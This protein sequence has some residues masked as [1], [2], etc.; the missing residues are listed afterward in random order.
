MN[1][2]DKGIHTVEFKLPKQRNRVESGVGGGGRRA[3]MEQALQGSC[4][5]EADPTEFNPSYHVNKILPLP[6]LSSPDGQWMWVL[7]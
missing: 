6:L 1:T 5:L 3:Q 7:A 2:F 4:L